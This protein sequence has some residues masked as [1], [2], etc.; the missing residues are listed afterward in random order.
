M[1]AGKGSLGRQP[2]QFRRLVERVEE[3]A[4]DQTYAERKEMWTRHHR[5]E[6]VAK[7]PVYVGLYVEPGDYSVVW[8]EH[9]SDSTSTTTFSTMTCSCP[10]LDQAG[11]FQGASGNCSKL[12]CRTWCKRGC[13]ET[14]GCALRVEPYGRPWRRL[15]GGP[16]ADLGGRSGSLSPSG[17]R[18]G[19]GGDSTPSRARHRDGGWKLKGGRAGI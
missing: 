9:A 12:R 2:V 15:Q 13:R 10:R 19:P 18:R 17:L 8:Q 1:A 4:R 14:M 3:A 11:T 6:H 16:R 5:L 7:A